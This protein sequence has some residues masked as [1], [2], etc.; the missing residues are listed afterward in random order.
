MWYNKIVGGLLKSPL[1][2]FMSNS[3]LLLTYQGRKS[4][5]S[6]SLPV[7]YVQDGKILW[8]TS[9]ADRTWW[10]NLLEPQQVHMQLKGEKKTGDAVAY[11][12]EE[13]IVEGLQHYFELAPQFAKYYQVR[14]NENNKP[15]LEDVQ[16]A[17][18]DRIIVRI[19]L[20]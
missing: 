3:T 20:N 5:K 15:E 18:K 7:N 12:Q 9:L 17:A 13:K 11:S 4:G 1:H 14:L 16:A 8:I 10:R 6:Y 2:G 19:D